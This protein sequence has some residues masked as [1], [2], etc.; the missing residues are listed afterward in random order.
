MVTGPGQDRANNDE[1]LRRLAGA[2]P[3]RRG[4]RY[5]SV[6]IFLRA[7]DAVPHTCT[8]SCH[9]HNGTEPVGDRGFGYDPLFRSDE[10]GK[11][12]GEATAEEKHSVSHRGRAFAEFAAWLEANPV[13]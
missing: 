1:L 4:A 9:G 12:F 3:D 5:Q 13:V 8:G 10:L 11:T 7:R 6:V 2:P